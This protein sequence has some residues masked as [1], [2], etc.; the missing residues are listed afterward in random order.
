MAFPLWIP[1][2]AWAAGFILLCIVSGIVTLYA[3]VAFVRG[4][5]DMVN[6]LVGIPSL[7]E[8]IEEFSETRDRTP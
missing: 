6:R 2:L 1:Q 3:C 8:E 5:H 4:R 7:G